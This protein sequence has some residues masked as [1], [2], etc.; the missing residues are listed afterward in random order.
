MTADCATLV[1]T[2]KRGMKISHLTRTTIPRAYCAQTYLPVKTVTCNV[3]SL[4]THVHIPD[5]ATF[6]DK[7][8][9]VASEAKTDDERE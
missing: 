3:K 8:Q 2:L 1:T 7:L 4:L 6:Y 5:S 9:A